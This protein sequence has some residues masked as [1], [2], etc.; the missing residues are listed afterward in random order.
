MDAMTAP[1][2]RRD[3]LRGLPGVGAAALLAR[4]PLEAA[5]V[6]EHTLGE[7]VASAASRRAQER[8]GPMSAAVLPPGFRSRFVENIN[9][10]RVHVLEA[11]FES[12]GRPAVLL[13]H[14]FPEL[15][16][17]WRNVMGPLA[18]AGYHVIVPDQ[19]GYGRTTGWDPRYDGDV[20]SYRRLNLGR[21]ALGLVYAFGYRSVAAVVGH[22]WGS[23]VASTLAVAR[24]DVFRSVVLMSAPFGGTGSL[25]FDTADDPPATSSATSG[26]SLEEALAALPRPRKHYT[27]NLQTREAAE[28]F[29]H[30]PQGL[31]DF[32]RAYHHF[33]SADWAG[34]RPYR[35][36]SRTA[37]VMAQMPEYYIL[38]L[39][40]TVSE[41]VAPHMPTP[42]QIAAN[43]W[44]PD[45]DLDVYVEEFQRTGF[46]GGMNWYRA[47]GYGAAERDMY[48][49]LT[50]DQPSA[51]IA[52]AAD[53]GSY[54]NP[55]VLER[56]QESACTDM[57]GV[58]MIPGAGHWVQQEQAAE[59]SRL[60]VDFLR[61]V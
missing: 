57:R 2:S 53:W 49:G 7:G 44:L 4:R 1:F 5:I 37:E 18:D 50:I 60:L 13:L 38:D 30:P 54:Q 6:D 55:G 22:D 19:R 31:K 20:A 24:P 26:P 59:T 45:H 36:A 39:H 41:T 35:L 16:F 23:P 8:L 48:A 14:G 3:L 61:G 58:H 28:D 47:G 21:D 51:Y 15:A 43:T 56:M 33:K 42:A 52:G 25:P 12:P 17:S 9:G 10:L 29:W 32:L 46:Q 11:G 40:K 27:D 34:N